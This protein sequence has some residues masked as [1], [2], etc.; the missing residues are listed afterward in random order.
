MACLDDLSRELAALRAGVGEEDPGGVLWEQLQGEGM[1]VF[2]DLSTGISPTRLTMSPKTHYLKYGHGKD[3][4]IMYMTR[5]LYHNLIDTKD[6]I[7][8]EIV[9]VEN[10]F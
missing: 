2:A 7:G 10:T 6:E 4:K 9:F 3:P 1:P 8:I 5:Y